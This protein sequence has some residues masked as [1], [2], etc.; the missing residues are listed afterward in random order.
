MLGWTEVQQEEKKEL[1]V[2][3]GEGT[4][5]AWARRRGRVC[6]RSLCECA[7]GGLFEAVRE[8]VAWIKSW[9]W[10]QVLPVRNW[11][12]DKEQESSKKRWGGGR[13]SAE[14]GRRKWVCQ[15]IFHMKL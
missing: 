4:L 12:L 7:R 3:K 10:Q 6:T 5:W 1:L 13:T 2:R 9:V 8:A 11:R 14:A 15:L